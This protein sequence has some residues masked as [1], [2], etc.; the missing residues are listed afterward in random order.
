MENEIPKV[1][2]RL[3]LLVLELESPSDGLRR[4][5]ADQERR[6]AMRKEGQIKTAKAKKIP[7]LKKPKQ[8]KPPK[9]PKATK[10][11]RKRKTKDQNQTVL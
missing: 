7:K 3:G 6:T 8:P 5:M 1:R 10:P 9:V 4:I 2:E 11:K